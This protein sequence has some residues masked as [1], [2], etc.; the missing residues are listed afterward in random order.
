MLDQI[1]GKRV[2]VTGATG[3]IGKHLSALASALGAHVLRTSRHGS[4][5]CIAMDVTNPDDVKHTLTRFSPEV[6][7]HL[8]SA[9][10]AGKST[11]SDLVSI[12][13]IGTANL[14]DSCTS[15]SLV[16]DLIIAGSGYEYAPQSRPLTE[17]DPT[18]PSSPY[19]ISKAA[20]TQ[21]AM[22]APDSIKVLVLR[23]FNVYGPGESPSRLLPYLVQSAL[24]GAPVKTTLGEQIRDFVH[25]GDV[26]EAFIR[27]HTIP[28]RRSPATLNLGSGS[29]IRLATF[30]EKAVS[31]LK[32]FKLDLRVEYGAIPY[33]AGEPMH[34]E[35]NTQKFRKLTGWQPQTTLDDGLRQTIS[36][37]LAKSDA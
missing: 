26:A 32:E 17:A 7:Y 13:T 35:A 25:V 18:I 12:N 31:I 34:Y 3:F 29:P 36:F 24:A 27:C 33:R 22:L 2:L 9:G 5:D 16:P 37:L 8:A 15:L 1:S 19:G 30:I 10:V 11:F 20:A 6:V 21:Y 14:L 28:Q 4:D 23:L